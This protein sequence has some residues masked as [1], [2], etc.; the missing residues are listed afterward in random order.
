MSKSPKITAV[1]SSSSAHGVTAEYSHEN[2]PSAFL[3]ENPSANAKEWSVRAAIGNVNVA[4]FAVSPEKKRDLVERY[5]FIQDLAQ[6]NASGVEIEAT[7]SYPEFRNLAFDGF[8]IDP[9]VVDHI[10]SADSRAEEAKRLLAITSADVENALEDEDEDDPYQGPIEIIQ[11]SQVTTV[12]VSHLVEEPAYVLAPGSSTRVVGLLL[13]SINPLWN[14]HIQNYLE[15]DSIGFDV[16]V[17]D[18]ENY[19]IL[20]D[21]SYLL[22]LTERGIDRFFEETASDEEEID[23]AVAPEEL[24]LAS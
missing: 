19:V 22:P 21:R 13:P 20:L 17:D 9:D 2:L 24:A 8:V 5:D 12:F 6:L 7:I 16:A 1:I 15:S 4:D 10:T 11:G 14:G 23:V 18:G 3:D